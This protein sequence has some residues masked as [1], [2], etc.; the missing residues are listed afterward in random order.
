MSFQPLHD[1]VK[2]GNEN[3]K[4][5]RVQIIGKKWNDVKTDTK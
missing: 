5:V 3:G 4:Y 1:M 2:N